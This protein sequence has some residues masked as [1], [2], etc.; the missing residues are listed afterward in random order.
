MGRAA[1][2]L[3]NAPHA[4]G[5]YLMKDARGGI[6]YIGK[7]KD[8]HAR[9]HQYMTPTS[10]SRAFVQILDHI[11]ADVEFFITGS[12]K[13]ALIL[14]NT[15]IK[16]HR[17]RF[18]VRIKDDKNYFSLRLDLKQDYPRL[19]IVRQRRK[20]DALYFGPYSSAVRARRMLALI[21][22]HFRLRT[23]SDRMF[24]TTA[25]PCM[26]Y[27]MGRCHAPCTLAVPRE[28][29]HA[30]AARVRL[31]LEGRKDLLVAELEPLMRQAAASQEFERA[32][33]LRDQI[34]AV[35]DSLE[36]QVMDL[37]KS[38]DWDVVG[39]YREGEAAV[40]AVVQVRFGRIVG[41]E[42][43]DVE[44]RAVS[45]QAAL[46]GFLS[47]Y[48]GELWPLPERILVPAVYDDAPALEEWLSERRGKKVEI[49][50]PARGPAARLLR[51]AAANAEAHFKQTRSA[52]AEQARLLSRLA[53][54]IGME[55]PPARI[56][57][58]DIS[59]VQGRLAV[60]SLVTFLN[61]RPEKNDYRRFRI[62]SKD[63]PDDF[64]MMRE[65]LTR[66]FK[67]GLEEGKLPDLLIVDGGK[68]QLNVALDV[69]RELAV[70]GVAAVGL[71]KSRLKEKI[72]PGQAAQAFEGKHRT[73]ERVFLPGK[74]NP[75]ILRPGTAELHLVQ[76]IR[77]EAH[78]F[79]ITY[80]RL[81]RS[82]R[83]LKSGL[84]EI[85][86]VGPKRARQLLSHFGS[87]RR[88]REATPEAIAALPGFTRP[89]AESVLAYLAQSPPPEP[90]EIE[91]PD[92]PVEADGVVEETPSDVELAALEAEADGDEANHNAD[93]LSNDSD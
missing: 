23:C 79:A 12:E 2:I 25:R 26:R 13:E 70:K 56:E 64:A 51:I 90:S 42:A 49:A 53:E 32:A 45:D 1:D 91:A 3:H 58:V 29:Y 47:Q 16:K 37:S 78:R 63:E 5:V 20:D 41:R 61:G 21:D 65:V 87:L 77:D 11:L 15:L 9:M 8:I 67:R 69:L 35:S 27:Q 33:K 82:R 84:L 86:G 62:Q 93:G 43:F 4:P 17:P 48:F 6:F 52:E 66:R 18:N 30:E 39:L 28:T 76:R 10:D 68:G 75:V 40:A 57:C 83:N 85:P 36:Q 59:N 92:E 7:A 71:A 19:E 73:P 44:C 74:K 50:A 22:K 46:S 60:G 81:L 88:V 80:H 89:L 34:R 24:R 14:E 31:F 55:L 72:G 54:A 38:V